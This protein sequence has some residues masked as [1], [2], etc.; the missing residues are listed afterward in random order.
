MDADTM[1]RAGYRVVDLLVE[2]L[3]DP[4]RPPLR[5]ATP[6][7]MAARLS[8]PAPDGPEALE[9]LLETL[10]RDVLPFSSRGDHPGFFAFVPFAGT[11]PGA[12][13]DLIAAAAN[14][15]AGSW[16]ESAGPS[17][18]EL[19]VLGWFAEWVGYAADAAGVLVS[20]GS[21]ANLTGLACAREAHAGVMTDRLVVY[22]SDQA[23]SSI[24]R[25][26]RVLG[27]RPDQV[28]VLPTG[29]DLTLRPETLAS[30]VRADLEA[31]RR[32][33][34]VC[35]T[36]GTT[37]SGAVDP[38]PE[39]ADVASEHGLWLHVDAAYG[40]FSVL[41]ERGRAALRGLERADSITLDP[42]KW[43]YQPYECGCILVRDGT[44]LRRAFE[45]VPDYLKD[46][47]ATEGEINFADLGIQLSRSSRALKCWLS[48]RYFGLDA[49]R[50]AI[51][52][53]LDLAELAARLVEESEELE[54]A[55][56]PSLGVVCFRRRSSGADEDA[57]STGLAAALEQSGRALVSTTRL[58][59]R[60]AIRMCILSHTS[61]EE[62]VRAA[63]EFLERAEPVLPGRTYERNP[64]V[65]AGDVAPAEERTVLELLER[66][67]SAE[68]AAAPGEI[69][70]RQ[71]DTSRDFYVLLDGSAEVQVDGEP[72]V[73]LGPG[74]FFGELA[75]LDWGAGF[76][77]SRLA[78]IVARTPLRLLVVPS[79]QLNS[80]IRERPELGAA[81]RR[82][83]HERL[84]RR[85]P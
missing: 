15:Y 62:H 30:A 10:R 47:E 21:A 41:T 2:Y 65:L 6:D 26:A 37:N 27:F 24:A 80:Q 1:R 59:G 63:L 28:R 16:M 52:R 64:D 12:L 77:Y 83:V 78:T 72:V 48:L 54:L 60:T 20:G 68:R 53:T 71:W 82:A 75:A 13:G 4:A 35:A 34:A 38:L 76:G 45:I 39:L 14:L 66:N 85:T 23:H 50:A 25:G 42:H 29:P 32:P 56:P 17:R 84:A 9:G 69:V 18:L 73:D 33:L 46:S 3:D 5:R 74:D 43:L 81:I 40:G 44:T 36:A 79:E 57:V 49:F 67:G 55:A 22:V 51:D 61:D 8:A 7:E 19:E 31:R 58:H 11:W 70:V